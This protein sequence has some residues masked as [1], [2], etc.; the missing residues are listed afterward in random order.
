MTPAE[1]LAKWFGRTPEHAGADAVAALEAAGY[2]IIPAPAGDHLRTRT[3]ND[4]GFTHMPPIP[5]R[6]GGHADVSE[7]S[8]ASHPCVC[9]SITCPADLNQP[10]GPT[11]NAVAH[12]GVEDAWRLAEQLQHVATHHYQG[13]G[14]PGW[15]T[16]DP[17]DFDESAL[18]Q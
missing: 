17:D 4:R 9:V 13:N 15:W 1:V 11:I 10:D 12:L 14:T 16:V 18:A 3:T 6:Y 8:A 7:S 2:R 5:S